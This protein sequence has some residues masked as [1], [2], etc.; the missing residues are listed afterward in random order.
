VKEMAIKKI[1]EIKGEE[2]IEMKSAKV[3]RAGNKAR[4]YLNDGTKDFINITDR[5]T[6][7]VFDFEGTIAEQVN[8]NTLR[9]NGRRIFEMEVIETEAEKL[10]KGEK[11]KGD[12][13]NA[14]IDMAEAGDLLGAVESVRDL[15][16]REED[17]N[18]VINRINNGK[19]K[20]K[21]N[22]VLDFLCD[23]YKIKKSLI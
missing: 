10:I 5:S 4:I 20:G 12:R 18:W 21:K 6:D 7:D 9:I 11:A 1:Y 19:E 14:A 22:R 16:R 17:Y 23:P 2:K 8:E 13:I 15:I 3:W